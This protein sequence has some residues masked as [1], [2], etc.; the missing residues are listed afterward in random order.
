MYERYM[1]Y[2]NY[3]NCFGSKLGLYWYTFKNYDFRKLFRI[4]SGLNWYAFKNM[5][6]GFA[7]EVN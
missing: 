2:T 3:R 1:P 6:V 4:K 5:I 7:L